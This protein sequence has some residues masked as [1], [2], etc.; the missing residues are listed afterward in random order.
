MD[1]D[2]RELSRGW[3]LV[4]EVHFEGSGWVFDDFGGSREGF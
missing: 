2:V 4:T 1:F 3:I